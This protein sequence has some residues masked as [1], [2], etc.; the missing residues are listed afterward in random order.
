MNAYVIPN[1]KQQHFSRGDYTTNP[2]YQDENMK[3]WVGYQDENMKKCK[4][5]HFLVTEQDIPYYWNYIGKLID[6]GDEDDTFEDVKELDFENFGKKRPLEINLN[7]YCVLDYE[8]PLN[9][10]D[11]TSLDLFRRT[12]YGV[13]EVNIV[14]IY[15]YEGLLQDIAKNLHQRANGGRNQWQKVS[16]FKVLDPLDELCG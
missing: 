14:E 8:N 13:R 15:R 6:V 5:Y 2:E 7:T 4:R 10:G 3:K 12:R 11:S 1:D 9:T 16:N